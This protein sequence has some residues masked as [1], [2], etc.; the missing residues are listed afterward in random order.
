MPMYSANSS[1]EFAPAAQPAAWGVQK[2]D[3]EVPSAV[4]A[5]AHDVGLRFAEEAN[6]IVRWRDVEGRGGHFAALEEPEMLVD[7]IREFVRMLR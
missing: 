2:Q 3:S 1:G 6:T 7:D 4:I 5:F